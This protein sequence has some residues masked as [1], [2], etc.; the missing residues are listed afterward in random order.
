MRG[1]WFFMEW[2]ANPF[3]SASL[4][5]F[6]WGPNFAFA[7][8]TMCVWHNTTKMFR[9][10]WQERQPLEK[11]IIAKWFLIFFAISPSKEIA[12]MLRTHGN[13]SYTE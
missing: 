13:R 6:Q 11:A 10:F 9:D 5:V 3:V 8:L 7:V 4:K 12:T 2:F 1:I